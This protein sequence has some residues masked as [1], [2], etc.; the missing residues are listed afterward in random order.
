M[1]ILQ[2]NSSSTGSTGYIARAIHEKLLSQGKDSFYAYGY[3]EKCIEDNTFNISNFLDIRIH[4]KLGIL[5]G[6][7]G[8]FSIFPTIRLLKR[9]NKIKPD[10]IHLHNI[11][12]SYVNIFLLLHFIKKEKMKIVFTLHDCWSFTGKC[13]HFTNIKCDKWKIECNNCPIVPEYQKFKRLDIVK[14]MYK[15]KKNSLTSFENLNIITVSKWL[16]TVT[17]HSYL[18]KFPVK[19]IYNG[20]DTTIFKPTESKIKDKFNVI[21]KFMILGVANYWDERK[22]LKDFIDLSK[23]IDKNSVIFLVGLSREQILNLPQNV[24]GLPRTE[25]KKELI[26]LYSAADVFINV[27]KEETF[28]MVSAEAMACGTPSIVYNSTAC[29]E[30]IDKTTG[31]LVNVNDSEGI[32]NAVKIVKNKSKSHYSNT[33]IQRIVDN[34]S[35]DIMVD[36]YLNLYNELIPKNKW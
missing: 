17:N 24:I 33:C 23:R 21:D 13:P 30:V 12:G 29:G 16:S 28:G 26:E 1:K 22:G 34:F 32:Y 19:V 4:G 8:C 31:V 9:I 10:I 2:I 36:N 5:T 27:S 7:D 3:G 20:I 18:G 6:F 35:K 11:H 15:N 25:N 14:K